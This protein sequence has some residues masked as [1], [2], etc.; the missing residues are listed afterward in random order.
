VK[1]LFI[2][3]KTNPPAKKKGASVKARVPVAMK[4]RQQK[5]NF[6]SESKICQ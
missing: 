2:S 6:A 3:G 4:T 5:E 1:K